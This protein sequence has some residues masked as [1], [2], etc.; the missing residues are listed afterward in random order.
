MSLSFVSSTFLLKMS[1]AHCRL[2]VHD[3]K[4]IAQLV[5]CF[6]CIP[7]LQYSILKKKKKYIYMYVYMYVY[8]YIY[9]CMY[10][11]VYMYI[12]I[13]VYM[14]ICI[15]IYIYIYIYMMY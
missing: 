13:Y 2:N 7:I 5:L 12:C 8:M 1:C 14:Y 15:Y 11:Y 3:F 4:T 9:I 6:S 10:V